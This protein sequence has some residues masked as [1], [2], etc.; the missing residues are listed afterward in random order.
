[1]FQKRWSEHVNK[2]GVNHKDRA[3]KES[4]WAPSTHIL[5]NFTLVP[6]NYQTAS[7]QSGDERYFGGYDGTGQE[8]AHQFVS[9]ARP[10]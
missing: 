4:V 1:M 2:T 6:A 3:L 7:S 9:A 8:E 5:L 10:L